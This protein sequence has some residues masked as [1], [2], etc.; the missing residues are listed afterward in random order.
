MDDMPPPR[1]FSTALCGAIR[2][3]PM[4][5][6][7]VEAM[8]QF[9]S[10]SPH[11]NPPERP[12][13]FRDAC[14]MIG[15]NP[16]EKRSRTPR[17]PVVTTFDVEDLHT[18]TR[19]WLGG[20][21]SLHDIAYLRTELLVA[22]FF[23]QG[24]AS[25]QVG[26]LAFIRSKPGIRRIH[27]LRAKPGRDAPHVVCRHEQYSRGK[28]SR[29]SRSK[30]VHAEL[31]RNTPWMQAI[32]SR[33][34]P[35]VRLFASCPVREERM[36]QEA[37]KGIF[38]NALQISI[39][40]GQHYIDRS[41]AIF[42]IF[43]EVGALSRED[44]YLSTVWLGGSSSCLLARLLETDYTSSPNPGLLRGLLRKAAVM[45]DR[46]AVRMILERLPWLEL[47]SYT[48]GVFCE[49][50]HL[51]EPGLDDVVRLLLAHCGPGFDVDTRFTS[52]QVSVSNPEPMLSADDG[53]T[54][55]H[56]ALG[57]GRVTASIELLRH[58]AKPTVQ[59]PDAG[60]QSN[61]MTPLR[62]LLFPQSNHN[63]L[64]LREFLQSDYVRRDHPT[65][66]LD[67]ATAALRELLRHCNAVAA[68]RPETEA[69]FRKLLSAR[70]QE[71]GEER[72][73]PIHI[74]AANGFAEAIELLAREGV[75]VLDRVGV[76]CEPGFAASRRCIS[77]ICGAL[78]PGSTIP[79]TKQT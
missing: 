56:F 15:G 4:A 61:G 5:R 48:V 9:V 74:A 65:F 78:L 1:R 76:G 32:A 41:I 77:S 36:R 68:E 79:G 27:E 6:P 39:A 2:E 34:V 33:L 52:R 13:S 26:R 14:I 8:A 75:D 22:E 35:L 50:I 47:S 49:A 40:C 46:D 55:L 66:I 12:S 60:R 51:G 54:L 11:K 44:A 24:E 17:L 10:R 19:Q 58:G 73:A 63:Y 31:G 70:M 64:A 38:S 45:A 69:Q 53:Q 59:S 67:N 72:M 3:L 21:A 29:G 43:W 57:R 20:P 71:D 18:M 25:G 28:I 7:A 23:R 42:S 30:P 16:D 62:H 37:Q